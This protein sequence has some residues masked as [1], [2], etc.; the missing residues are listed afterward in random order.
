MAYSFCSGTTAKNRFLFLLQ[1]MS[2]IR[3]VSL[4]YK[5][6]WFLDVVTW[7]F[8][9]PLVEVYCWFPALVT[10]FCLKSQL[11]QL[12]R[13]LKEPSAKAKW[14]KPNGKRRIGK[15]QM[16]SWMKCSMERPF[17][18]GKNQME[19]WNSMEKPKGNAIEKPNGKSPNNQINSQRIFQ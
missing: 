10:W 17:G 3:F 16:E 5:F 6:F 19:T 2:P 13:R 7:V 15:P 18:K 1:A 11:V 12:K 14:N 8:H 4:T 9:L